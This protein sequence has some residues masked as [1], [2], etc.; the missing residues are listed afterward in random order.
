LV[1]QNLKGNEMTETEIR[2]QEKANQVAK[3]I[4]NQLGGNRKL[5]AMIAMHNVYFSTDSLSQGFLQF[6]FKGCRIASKVRIFLEY[7]DTYTLK[8]YSKSGIEKHTIQGVY[9]DM[10]IEVFQNH[11]KLYLSL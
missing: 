6:D 8:F 11:T 2:N 10:L 3:E 7:N 9:N 5:S 4:L 1:D